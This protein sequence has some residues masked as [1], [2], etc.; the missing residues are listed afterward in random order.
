M[1]VADQKGTDRTLPKLLVLMGEEWEKRYLEE[2][3]K[4]D[5]MKTM[6]KRSKI[7]ALDTVLRE[8]RTTMADEWGRN[9]ASLGY[10]NIYSP[11]LDDEIIVCRDEKIAKVLKE[12][13]KQK[14]YTEKEIEQFRNL[15]EEEMRK[16]HEAHEIFNGEL[17]DPKQ[18]G[19]DHLR[20]YGAKKKTRF[21]QSKTKNSKYSRFKKSNPS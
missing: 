17:V 9:F 12:E 16:L 6:N 8:V 5:Q 18:V 3:D 7:I 2:L 1:A 4:A 19:K 11:K 14:V 21:R 20:N 13:K 15:T 10:C